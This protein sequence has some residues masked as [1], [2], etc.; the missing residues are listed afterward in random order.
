MRTLQHEIFDKGRSTFTTRNDVIDMEDRALPDL[1]KSAIPATPDISLYHRNSQR[2]R[3]SRDAHG[4]PFAPPCDC[5]A[6]ETISAKWAICTSV[7]NSVRSIGE[8]RPSVF[9]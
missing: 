6:I 8:S 3:N 9:R 7:C 2:A 1:P 5:N 4:F